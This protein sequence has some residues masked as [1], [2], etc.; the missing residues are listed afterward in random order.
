[1][2]AYDQIWSC[3]SMGSSG[4]RAK[5][6]RSYGWEGDEPEMLGLEGVRGKDCVPLPVQPIGGSGP[7]EKDI[8]DVGSVVLENK[9]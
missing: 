7:L 2:A 1:M 6:A 9:V 5:V 3:S 8:N 4:K